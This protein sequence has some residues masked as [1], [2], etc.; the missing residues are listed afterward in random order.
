MPCSM[1]RHA[2]NLTNPCLYRRLFQIEEYNIRAIV[3]YSVLTRGS[4]ASYKMY[5]DPLIAMTKGWAHDAGFSYSPV[6]N[7]ARQRRGTI[8]V[9]ACANSGV[10]RTPH[11]TRL[12]FVCRSCL[13]CGSPDA[14]PSSMGSELR[15][16]QVIGRPR[17]SFPN[18]TGHRSLQCRMH[19]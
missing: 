12:Q 15:E 18:L 2:A 6:I 4:V 10:R 3:Q 19:I 17:Y 9:L 7:I 8:V 14:G 5:N 11:C 13:R 16:R 1:L